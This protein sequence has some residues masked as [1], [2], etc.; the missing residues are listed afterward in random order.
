VTVSTGQG[1]WKLHSLLLASR[2]E[3]FYRCVVVWCWPGLAH[4]GWPERRLGAGRANTCVSRL[5][6]ESRR[7]GQQLQPT[8]G[9][10][11]QARALSL[12]PPPPAIA[13]CVDLAPSRN[14]NRALAGQFT[15]SK[16]KVI[17]LHLEKSE[18]VRVCGVC[19]CVCV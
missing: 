11:S 1:D 10:L 3:F 15:E 9:R 17:E 4:S 7:V 12:A 6:C 8:I 18:E 14:N 19:V 5:G 13:L 16:S 2:S